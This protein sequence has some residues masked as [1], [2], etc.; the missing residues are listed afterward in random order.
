MKNLGILLSGRGSNFEAIA[1]N[2]S[3]G[4]IPDARIAVVISNRSDAGGVE[5]ARGLGLTTLVIPSKGRDRAEHDREVVAALHKQRVDLVCLAGYMRLLSPW[6]VRQFPRRI[7][8]IH[9]S[10]L[11][12]FPG[13]EAQE[14]AFAYGVKVS[15]CTVHFVDEELDHGAIILQKTVPVL[16]TDDEHTLAARILEQEHIAY[17]EAI[18]I[19]LDGKFEIAGRRLVAGT[20]KRT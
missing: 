7:L 6:F 3:A 11:P 19:V 8:N 15:G 13:L 16:D 12:A 20:A 9:P 1:R 2:I 5:T 17:S 18:N 10:L 4:R 14:Q